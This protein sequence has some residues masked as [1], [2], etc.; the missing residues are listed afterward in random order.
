MNERERKGVIPFLFPAL[1]KEVEVGKG[2][3][4]K[5]LGLEKVGVGKS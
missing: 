4:W 3:G 5:R 2:W 1:L